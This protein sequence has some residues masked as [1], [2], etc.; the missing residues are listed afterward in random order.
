MTPYW[1]RREFLERAL[2][3]LGSLPLLGMLGCSGASSDEPPRVAISGAL[4]ATLRAR[5]D[6]DVLRDYFGEGDGSALRELGSR[7]LYAQLADLNPKDQAVVAL[8]EPTIELLESAE[9]E[10]VALTRLSA[11][12]E[13]EFA[14]RTVLDLAG[15]T[16]APSELALAALYFI[17][18]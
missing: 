10:A 2:L 18:H 12:I 6:G 4:R 16:L 9:S 8:L 14:D 3:Q 17:V 15:W 11:A 7:F 5:L 13:Q 1:S